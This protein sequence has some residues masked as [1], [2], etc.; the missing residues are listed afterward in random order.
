[1]YYEQ[2][3]MNKIIASCAA[4]FAAAAAEPIAFDYFCNLVVDEEAPG[5]DGVTDGPVYLLLSSAVRSSALDELDERIAFAVKDYDDDGVIATDRVLNW[6][7]LWAEAR[8]AAERLGVEPEL[9]ETVFAY[10]QGAPTQRQRRVVEYLNG[11]L[12]LPRAKFMQVLYNEHHVNLFESHGASKL[13]TRREEQE[14]QI[15]TAAKRVI[16]GR[17]YYVLASQHLECAFEILKRQLDCK[18]VL[19]MEFDFR[20]ARICVR[21]VSTDPIFPYITR[22]GV[23]TTFV[24]RMNELI[25]Y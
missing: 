22:C 17:V 13:S 9:L 11:Y 20:K 21:E 6:Y 18:S 5:F 8:R 23:Y 12:A 4:P 3:I 14:R 10:Y 7:D 24:I 2:N 16:D 1:M 15:A 19:L 25:D